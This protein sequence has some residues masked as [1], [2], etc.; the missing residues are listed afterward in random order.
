MATQIAP[1][2]VVRGKEAR[3][4]LMQVQQKPSA[5]AEAGAKKLIEYFEKHFGK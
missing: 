5:K 1:T 3:R 4:I 2:P